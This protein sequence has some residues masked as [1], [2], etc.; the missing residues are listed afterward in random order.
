MDTGPIAAQSGSYGSGGGRQIPG[1][2]VT[3][4][5]TANVSGTITSYT[6]T[7][8][9][10]N[11][12]GADV[13]TTNA[14]LFLLGGGGGGWGA[15][16]GNAFNGTSTAAGAAAGKAINTNGNAVTWISGSDRAYGAV[17]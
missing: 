4:T 11:Q 5:L 12:T 10:A 9:A 17:G 14:G 3:N 2:Q 6:S 13:T 8:G 15:R 7:G 16:G 1:T